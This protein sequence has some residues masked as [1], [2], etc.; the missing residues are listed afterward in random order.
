LLSFFKEQKN[1]NKRLE[2]AI[3]NNRQEIEKL[4]NELLT[5]K[6]LLIKGR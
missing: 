5:I 3:I 4:K 2:K 6:K 1:I